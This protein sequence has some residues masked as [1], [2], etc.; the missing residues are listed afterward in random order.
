MSSPALPGS[1]CRGRHGPA[2]LPIG[3]ALV[4]APGSA[5]AG[6]PR[7]RAA[8]GSGNADGFTLLELIVATAVL[9]IAVVGLLSLA[10]GALANAALVREYDRAAMLARTTMNELMVEDGLPL[11]TTMSGRYGEDSGW[12]ARLEPF[13]LPP[14][15]A[16]GRTMLVRIQLDVWWRSQGRRKSVSLESFRRMIIRPEHGFDVAQP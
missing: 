3:A 14:R 16:A 1:A 9:A 15:P 11:G 2:G 6:G 4:A 12:A 13:E 10:S 7:R 5:F 8:H